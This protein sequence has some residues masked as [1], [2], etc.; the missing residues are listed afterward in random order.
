M[1]GQRSASEDMVG[2][3]AGDIAGHCAFDATFRDGGS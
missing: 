2:E 3:M 1:T